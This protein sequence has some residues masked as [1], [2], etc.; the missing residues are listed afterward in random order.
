MPGARGIG[1]GQQLVVAFE[2][3]ARRA[4]AA[5]ATLMTLEG[6]AGAGGFYAELGWT[7]ST[8]RSTPDGRPTEDWVRALRQP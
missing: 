3:E 7:R 1:A 6:T 2:A 4:G 5:R 8:R